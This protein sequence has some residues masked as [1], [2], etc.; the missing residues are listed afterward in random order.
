MSWP[1]TQPNGN[2][3]VS[4]GK[5]LKVYE[6]ENQQMFEQPVD[7]SQYPA[8]LVFLLGQGQLTESFTLRTLDAAQM[9]F[10]GGYVLE[11]TP[12]TPTPAYQKV[13]LYVDSATARCGACSSSTRRATA[14]A[15]TSTTRS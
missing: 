8:A 7:K 4:D 3:V 13:L 15:S 10:E 6:K 2:R 5:I 11:G 1:T 14:T 12:R 9:N